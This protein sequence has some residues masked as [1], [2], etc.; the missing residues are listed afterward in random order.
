MQQQSS[1]LICCGSKFF[2]R[3][4]TILESAWPVG[5]VLGRVTQ[6][7][8]SRGHCPPTTI[9]HIPALS[10]FIRTLSSPAPD[11]RSGAATDLFGVEAEKAC[12][13]GHHCP[14]PPCPSL[15]FHFR[16]HLRPFNTGGG[17]AS[18]PPPPSAC[19]ACWLSAGSWTTGSGGGRPVTQPAGWSET[20]QDQAALA[21]PAALDQVPLSLGRMLKALS[22][23]KCH[24]SGT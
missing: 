22:S 16:F 14:L 20:H 8:H 24:N 4:P 23:K 2:F 9:A 10:A 17:L 13:G 7:L 5:R 19:T 15:S 6:W 3:S 18:R 11:L 12:D 21:A 1:K